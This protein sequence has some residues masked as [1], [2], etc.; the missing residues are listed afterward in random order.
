MVP[1]Y[2]LGQLHELM[3]D[4]IINNELGHFTMQN[5]AA[6][7]RGGWIDQQATSMKAH[8]NDISGHFANKLD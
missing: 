4:H 8:Q 3:R 6:V 2:N 1:F 5:F 7:R